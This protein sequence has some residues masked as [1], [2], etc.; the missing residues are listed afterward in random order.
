M[1]DTKT[2]TLADVFRELAEMVPE[3]FRVFHPTAGT[4]ARVKLG[5]T[6]THMH[7]IEGGSAP[8]REMHALIQAACQ[9]E[10][11]ARGWPW[12]ITRSVTG[13][14]HASI[15]ADLDWPEAG[16]WG[17]SPTMVLATALRDALKSTAS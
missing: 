6:L 13:R 1:V 3:R 15:L 5:D 16:H 2:E 9:E 7:R 14:Y 11:E 8:S 10:C 4:V 17:D 12:T